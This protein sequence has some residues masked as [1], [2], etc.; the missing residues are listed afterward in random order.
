VNINVV[1]SD[2]HVKN[3]ERYSCLIKNTCLL[4]LGNI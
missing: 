1:S 2:A 4:L 3:I